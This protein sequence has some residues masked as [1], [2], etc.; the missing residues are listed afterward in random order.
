VNVSVDPLDLLVLLGEA[1]SN[2]GFLEV[3]AEALKEIDL[4]HL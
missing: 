3:L 1:A 2:Q 4:F